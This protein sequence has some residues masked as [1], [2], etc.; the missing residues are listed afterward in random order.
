M[1]DQS[2]RRGNE[3]LQVNLSK[4]EFVPEKIKGE[5]EI[6]IVHHDLKSE[7][8]AEEVKEGS[9]CEV[10]G[11]GLPTLENFFNPESLKSCCYCQYQKDANMHGEDMPYDLKPLNFGSDC[12]IFSAK[13]PEETIVIKKEVTSENTSSTSCE[14]KLA[15][16][17]F[18]SGYYSNSFGEGRIHEKNEV[19]SKNLDERTDGKCVENKTTEKSPVLHEVCTKSFIGRS[20]LNN[21]IDSK[22]FQSR[23]CTNS[24]NLLAHWFDNSFKY[25]AD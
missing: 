12:G 11:G 1:E 20:D 19:F 8:C 6:T 5:D 7:Q 17:I 2:K 24:F 15:V 4:K 9:Y 21:H 22:P 10:C 25:H 13:P 3:T 16:E 14:K 18:S 23:I